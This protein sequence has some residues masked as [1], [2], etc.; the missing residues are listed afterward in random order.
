MAKK[1]RKHS[2]LAK[3]VLFLGVALLGLIVYAISKENHSKKQ[4]QTQ[5]DQLRQEAEKITRENSQLTEKLSYLESRDFQERE[6][7]DKLNMQNPNEN[8]VIVEP[9]V[10]TG[11]IKQESEEKN[12]KKLVVKRTNLQK[13]W[14]YFFKY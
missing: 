3:I 7:R 6:A 4:V 10:V 14:D 5:I 9:G 1:E 2:F 11:G 12:G 8:M 13:W